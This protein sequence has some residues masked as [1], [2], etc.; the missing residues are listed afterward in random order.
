VTAGFAKSSQNQFQ[1]IGNGRIVII[2]PPVETK[3]SLI[4][5]SDGGMA[6]RASFDKRI[7]LADLTKNARQMG[8]LFSDNNTD[9]SA[10]L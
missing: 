9:I 6:V 1:Y 3:F 5:R 8:L 4:S 10:T 2:R 7:N